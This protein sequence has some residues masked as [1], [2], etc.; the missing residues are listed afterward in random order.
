MSTPLAPTSRLPWTGERMIPHACDIA[1]EVLHW[2]R[3]LF[4]RPWYNQAKMIDAA[5]GEGYGLG[6]AA[7]FAAQALGYDIA[8]DAVAHA[9]QRYPHAEYRVSDVCNVDFSQADLVTSFETIEHLKDP[10]KFLHAL[11]ACTGRVVISTPSREHHSPGNKLSDKPWNEHHT[12]EWTP[13]EFADLI[14]KTYPDQQ[15]RFLS[16]ADTWPG[17]ITEGFRE[18]ARYLIAILG[19]GELPTWPS[20]G[21]AMPTVDNAQYVEHAITNL[22]KYYPGALHVAVVAN[23][24]PT[25]ALQQLQKLAGT[26]PQCVTLIEAEKNLGY[27][28]GCNLGLDMLTQRGGFD[29]LGVIN[30][31]IIP[32][33]DCTP[34]MVVAMQEIQSSGQK[35]G[36]IAPVSNAVNGQQLVDLGAYTNMEEMQFCAERYHREHH[37]A[38]TQAMQVRGLYMLMDPEA[39]AKVGG[40][41]PIFGIGNFEDDDLNLRMRL[42]GYSL[43]VADG[44]FLHHHGSSTFRAMKVDYESNI[45]RNL[46]VFLGKWGLE[47]FEQSFAMDVTPDGVSLHVPFDAVAPKS[48]HVITINGDLVDLVHQ[49]S[50]FDLAAWIVTSL[51]DKPREARQAVLDALAAA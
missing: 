46:A 37:S 16:Q 21:L 42:A 41:D 7:T 32:A 40:F 39:L 51:R 36:V 9:N 49:A 31:D 43:W 17:L 28:R 11:K 24:T 22:T 14:R 34:Q 12:I 6:Y 30:D 23:G 26:I 47:A 10:E 18:D 8:P 4:F 15:V 19:D 2:Q 20:I 5:S 33:V 38:A 29:Y 1:T 45:I 25:P 50:E 48:N 3:Y 35:P 27:G 44:A 13:Q